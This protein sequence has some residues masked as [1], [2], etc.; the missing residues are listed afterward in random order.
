[1]VHPCCSGSDRLSEIDVALSSLHSTHAHSAEADVAMTSR[2]SMATSVR[3][4]RPIML[5]S[6]PLRLARVNSARPAVVE[7]RADYIGSNGDRLTG[8]VFL[9]PQHPIHLLRYATVTLGLGFVCL[10]GEVHH[11]SRLRAH[12]AVPQH[13]RAFGVGRRGDGQHAE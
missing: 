11:L 12:V 1:M 10:R 8:V 6:L 13:P 2:Q 9:V 7:H 5:S 3:N 4:Q